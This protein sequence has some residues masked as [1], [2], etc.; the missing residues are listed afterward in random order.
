MLLPPRIR[1]STEHV[2]HEIWEDKRCWENEIKYNN[3]RELLFYPH[4]NRKSHGTEMPDYYYLDCATNSI[5]LKYK[6][7]I[8]I[9]VESE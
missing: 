3:K 6:N 4:A 7:K 8:E 5:N 1:V 9:V 2:K